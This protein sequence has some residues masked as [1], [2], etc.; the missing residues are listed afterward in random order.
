MR[1]AAAGKGSAQAML[2]RL[3]GFLAMLLLVWQFYQW[4]SQKLASRQAGPAADK[5]QAPAEAGCGQG[6]LYRIVYIL[7]R[8]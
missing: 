1:R 2:K 5:T 8:A 7:K 6:L 4:A 3:L